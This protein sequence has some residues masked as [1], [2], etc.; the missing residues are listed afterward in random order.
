M[1]DVLDP[2]EVVWILAGG[3]LQAWRNDGM[4]GLRRLD[5]T[6]AL[7]QEQAG[8]HAGKAPLYRSQNE[9]A[10]LN[11]PV[12]QVEVKRPNANGLT[13]S[14]IDIARQDAESRAQAAGWVLAGPPV[15]ERWSPVRFMLGWP[16]K[17]P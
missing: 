10:A 3:E 13:A 12:M 4:D 2:Q 9:Q 7:A 1:L 14:G 15:I 8:L 5:A 16:T 11:G 6:A 17:S